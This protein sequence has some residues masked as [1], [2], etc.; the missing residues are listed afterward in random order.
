MSDD[1]LFFD[2]MKSFTDRL[3]ANWST[4]PVILPNDDGTGLNLE[5]GFVGVTKLALDSNPASINGINPNVRTTGVILFDIHT[6]INTQAGLG[7]TYAGEI[8]TVFRLKQF[9]NVTTLTPRV[10]STEQ[11]EYNK[12]K[13]WLTRLSCP[14]Y[15]DVHVTL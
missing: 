10:A 8:G 7:L 5:N 12:S 3:I 9:N 14:F 4:L 6:L 15:H 1:T 2:I 11:T 13:Y